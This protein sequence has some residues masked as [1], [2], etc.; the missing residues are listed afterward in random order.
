MRR[1]RTYEVGAASEHWAH[2]SIAH[3]ASTSITHEHDWGD[4]SCGFGFCEFEDVEMAM[5]VCRNL[6]GRELNGRPL[7]I[8][9]AMNAP[10]E[11]L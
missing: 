8:D 1:G 5:S 7:L 4:E 10:G 9:R 6:A 3:W 11:N 2:T